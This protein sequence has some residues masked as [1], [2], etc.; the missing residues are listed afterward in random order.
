[1]A[2]KNE[3][4]SEVL[5]GIRNTVVE[6]NK[7]PEPKEPKEPKKEPEKKQDQQEEKILLKKEKLFVQKGEIKQR[8][9]Q[10]VLRP[11]TYNALME[12]VRYLREETDNNNISLNHVVTEVLEAFIE[13][14]ERS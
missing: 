4:F 7:Q 6:L 9:V 12:I 3:N 13:G 8:R 2:R 11:S 5:E 1:M 10:L 14:F